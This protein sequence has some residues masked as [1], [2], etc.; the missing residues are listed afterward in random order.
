MAGTPS[1]GTGRRAAVLP[2]L[3][4]LPVLPGLCGLGAVMVVALATPSSAAVAAWPY[5]AGEPYAVRVSH[6]QSRPHP[7]DDGAGKAG[8]GRAGTEAGAEKGG[9]VEAA[10]AV[11]KLSI[12]IDNGRT[13]TK[14]GDRLT[15]TVTVH[16]IGTTDARKLRLVQTMP[17]GLR[18]VSADGHGTSKEGEVAWNVDLPAGKDATFHTTAQVLATPEDLLRLATIAC[19]SAAGGDRPIVCA[20]HSDQLPAGA[21]AEAAG[22]AISSATDRPWYI[23]TGAAL[24]AVATLGVW[25][26]RKGKF[27]FHLRQQP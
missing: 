6:G 23:P 10:G 4:A 17:S 5:S 15:Y 12:G 19:A 27:P 18:F 26:F 7:E 2:V 1:T 8:A 20:T 16:N 24:L 13:T 25:A 3:P 14:E 11:P 22:R 9:P 21:A